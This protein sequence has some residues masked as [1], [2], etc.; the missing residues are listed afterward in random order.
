M[1]LYLGSWPLSLLLRVI[2][3]I[4]GWAVAVAVI[5]GSVLRWRRHHPPPSGMA[6]VLKGSRSKAP[7]P[8][9]TDSAV[10]FIEMIQSVSFRPPP[11]RP[12]GAVGRPLPWPGGR[13][14]D[15]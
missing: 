15:R 7:V 2:I 4:I 10:L 11:I 1:L 12:A 5:V 13:R 6:E 3:L 14:C 9:I 8:L